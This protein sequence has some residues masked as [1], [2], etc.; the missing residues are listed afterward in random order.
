MFEFSDQATHHKANHGQ[1][2]GARSNRSLGHKRNSP[3]L[4]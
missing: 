2:Q 4:H 1:R 3:L